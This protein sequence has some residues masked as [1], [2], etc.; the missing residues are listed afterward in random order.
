M[1]SILLTISLLLLLAIFL[2]DLKERKVY[3]FLFPL[4]AISLAWLNYLQL[5]VQQFLIQNI[6]NIT[7]V[8]AILIALSVYANVKMK[9]P[10]L[11]VFGLG[12]LLFFFTISVALPSV[13]FIV[14]FVAAIFFSG[15]LHLVSRQNKI[16]VPLAGYMALFFACCL[17]MNEVGLFQDIY[18]Y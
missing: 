3:W 9:R 1:R 5:G 4:A 12:D 14:L 17:V 18:S 8:S 6:I 7:I 15:L 13:S 16:T 2:Q 10:F 11:E